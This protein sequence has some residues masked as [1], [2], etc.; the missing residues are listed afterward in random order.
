M[1]VCMHVCI[2][3]DLIFTATAGGEFPSAADLGSC[4]AVLSHGWRRK[5]LVF[6][7][8]SS[9]PSPSYHHQAPRPG[10]HETPALP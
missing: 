9:Y 10:S 1:Y 5:V 2:Y 4:Q 8:V 7:P 6:F 3:M